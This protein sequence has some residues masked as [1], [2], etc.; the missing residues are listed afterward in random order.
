MMLA[1]GA[2]L[3][4]Q[5]DAMNHP[6]PNILLICVDQWRADC[7]G[8]EGH[9]TVETPHLD[10]LAQNGYRF[11]HA[12][13]ATPTCVPA[14]A[15]LLTGLTPSNHGFVGYDDRRDWHYETTLPSVLADAGYHTQ[16]I[17]K[18]HV[19]PARNLL[20]FHNVVLHDGFLHRERAKTDDS[21]LID[22][23]RYWL[24]DE[25][26]QGT[27]DTDSGIACNGYVAG[28]WPYHER[29]HPTTWT[30]QQSIDF[31]RRRDPTKPF[32]L[33]ASYHRPH[34][35]LDPPA[36][37][38]ERYRPKPLPEIPVGDWAT[39]ELPTHRGYDSPVPHDAAQQD[40]ARR[41]YYAQMTFIDHQLN[42][43]F[44]A[45]FQSGAWAKT[46]IF[47]VSD[48]GEMLF[49][50]NQVGKAM[51]FEASARVPFI[52]SLPPAQAEHFGA[53]APRT[54]DQLV[55]LRDILPTC[56]DLAGVPIPDTVDGKSVLP[57][58]RGETGGWREHLHG[59]HVYGVDS[60]QWLVTEREKYVWY[61]Q[62]GRELLF[63]IEADK[64]EMH[65]HSSTH[66]E[67]TAH[68]REL[69]IE[70]L[71]GREEGFVA[72]GALIAGRPQSA[73]LPHAGWGRGNVPQSV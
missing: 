43:L 56:C 24:R 27:D 53:D 72:D 58:L 45:L 60:N 70:E 16:C 26:G 44:M 38:L 71:E 25:L 52:L 40:Y 10:R 67:R 5:K 30:T 61:S 49:E 63:D 23:Y 6:P 19:H 14:R 1:G 57:L 35:P 20:G 28:T 69:L 12:Y 8:V 48:H 42:R 7:L 22:D 3:Q 2:S 17:G 13:S 11:R 18:M 37:F 47:F 66:P 32:F 46:A 68:F 62:S 41:A 15:G 59:E 4:L 9:P 55:E 50:H 29:H 64:G 36:S 73:T 31:L 65:D 33:K 51:P 39:P 34:P 54:V 21:G